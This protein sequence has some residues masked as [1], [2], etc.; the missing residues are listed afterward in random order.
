LP[1]KDAFF[2]RLTKESLTDADYERALKVWNHYD[3]K[4][5]QQYHNFYLTTDVLLLTDV[6]ESFRRT[7]LNAHGLDY[8]RFPSLP[9]MTLQMA[10]KITDVEL[11]LITDP[12]MY[13]MFESGIRGGLSYVSQRHACK[14]SNVTRLQTDVISCLLQFF[15]CD[16]PDVQS[17]G[18]KFPFS[19]RGRN[20]IVRRQ[21]GFRR[22][23]RRIRT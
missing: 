19:G 10:L 13:L 4:N 14:L 9:S 21:Y 18:G 20:S 3:I 1:P 5:L 8:L 15:V 16:H 2:N 7:M 22:F 6:F 12:D 17:T 11:D 23:T